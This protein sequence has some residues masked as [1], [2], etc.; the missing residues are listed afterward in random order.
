MDGNAVSSFLTLFYGRY[1]SSMK[2]PRFRAA[3]AVCNGKIVICGGIG[4]RNYKD[5]L[6][7]VECF[8]PESGVWTELRDIAIGNP[9]PRYGHSLVSYKDKLILMGGRGKMPCLKSVMELDP[10]K[11]NGKWKG[12]P[13]LKYKC[14]DLMGATLDD[15][16]YAIGGHGLYSPLTSRYV[17]LERV[18]VLEKNGKT[19]QE[20]PDLPQYSSFSA[21]LIVPQSFADNLCCYTDDNNRQ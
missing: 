21:A 5:F 9:S 13:S 7:S 18:E 1:F 15:K 20:G 11:I 8:D 12:L 16:I 3:A 10:S 6:S 19:W 4:D 17:T 14:Y 2:Y